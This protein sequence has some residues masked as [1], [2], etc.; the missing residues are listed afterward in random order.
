MSNRFST[1]ALVA[2]SVMAVAGLAYAQSTSERSRHFTSP[3]DDSDTSAPWDTPPMLQ[4]SV[5][6]PV[7]VSEPSYSSPSATV[8]AP[9]IAE[10]APTTMAAAPEPM[11]T[12]PTSAGTTETMTPPPAVAPRSDRN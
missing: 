10:P 6:P 4:Q 3:I 9:A 2:A 1:A 11:A 7:V 12:E 8:A 5:A